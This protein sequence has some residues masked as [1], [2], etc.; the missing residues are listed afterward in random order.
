MLVTGEPFIGDQLGLEDVGR[1]QV[2]NQ[3]TPHALCF[4]ADYLFLTNILIVAL[5]KAHEHRQRWWKSEGLA[6]RTFVPLLW[7][8]E[9]P[10]CPPLRRHKKRLLGFKKM[11]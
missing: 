4:L 11:H 9:T 5:S 1:A 10:T 8:Q 2:I 7:L 6:E 3:S